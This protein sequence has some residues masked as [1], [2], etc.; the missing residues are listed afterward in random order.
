MREPKNSRGRREKAADSGMTLIELVAVLAIF[1][2]VAVMGMQALTGTLRA[3]ERLDTIEADTAEISLALAL[4]RNDLRKAVPVFFQQPGG[5]L[6]SAI[7]VERGRLLAF[8]LA[9]Q[10][11]LDGN[12][13]NGLARVEW[14]FEPGSGLLTRSSW[15]VLLPLNSAARTPKVEVLAGVQGLDVRSYDLNKG[16]ISGVTA[17][18]GGVSTKLPDLIEVSLRTERFQIIQVLVA[19]K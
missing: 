4:L 17:V 15:P 6:E 10:P 19:V 12:E 5:D 13:T 8:T 16:W 3:R 11:R 7:V 9:G 14:R 2:L 18:V 1:A